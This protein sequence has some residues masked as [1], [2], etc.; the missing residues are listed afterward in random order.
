MT[1]QQVIK[2]RRNY[3]LLVGAAS[4]I[5]LPTLALTILK[6][7]FVHEQQLAQYN[8]HL[9][10]ILG[11]LR[12]IFG[13]IPAL[14]PVW[15][16]LSDGLGFGWPYGLFLAPTALVAW[17]LAFL[18]GHSVNTVKRLTRRLTEVRELV[19]KEEMAASRRPASTRQ[20]VEGV[21]SGRDTVINLTSHYN[22]RPDSPKT[23][24]SVAMIGAFGA[25]AAAVIGLL[26]RS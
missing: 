7:T 9:D 24:L 6:V 2:N 15:P 5:G 20:S 12:L 17:V 13:V 22:H 4:L 21:T 1:Y 14:L 26:H 18:A 23:T 10:P 16:W 11:V 8:P 3:V 25:V 19:D